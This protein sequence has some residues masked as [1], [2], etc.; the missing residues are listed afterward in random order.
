MMFSIFIF[1][2]FS[3]QFIFALDIEFGEYDEVANVEFIIAED[4]KKLKDGTFSIIEDG[5]GDKPKIKIITG[6]DE[7]ALATVNYKDVYNKMGWGHFHAH[8]KE[9]KEHTPSSQMYGAGVLEG[10]ITAHRI[11]EWKHNTDDMIKKMEPSYMG[12]RTNIEHMFTE[13]LNHIREKALMLKG[14]WKSDHSHIE[15]WWSQAR[16]MLMQAKGIQDGFNIQAKAKNVPLLTMV[17]LMMLSSDGETSELFKAYAQDEYLLRQEDSIADDATDDLL[18][19]NT[20]S[21]KKTDNLSLMQKLSHEE[22]LTAF[23]KHR[24]SHRNLQKER[25]RLHN[26]TDQDWNNI[27]RQTGRCSA[28]IKWTGDDLLTGHATWSDYA[29]MNRIFK[30]YDFPLP[31]TA[32]HKIS[33]SSYPGVAGST[34]DWYLMD[35]GLAVTETT[36]SMLS[37]E[38]YDHI[39]DSTVK[40]LIPDY[41]RIMA[42]NRLSKT[43]KDWVDMMIT[44]ATGTYSSQW[45]IIDYKLFKPNA[46]ALQPHTFWV[47]EQIPSMNHAQDMTDY[48]KKTSFW[49]SYNRA[50]YDETRKVMDVQFAET[51]KY[52]ALFGKATSPRANI[53]KAAQSTIKNVN[54]L[55]NLMRQNKWPLEIDGGPGNTADHAIAA[56]GD[57]TPYHS[58]FGAVDAKVTN[59]VLFKKLTSYAICGPMSNEKHQPFQWDQRPEYKFITHDGQPNIFNFQ[60]VAM[61]PSDI[62]LLDHGMQ[63]NDLGLLDHATTLSNTV[64]KNIQEHSQ[65]NVTDKTDSH[66]KEKTKEE[67]SQHDDTDKTD[68]HTVQE[69]NNLSNKVSQKEGTQKTVNSESVHSD[70]TIEKPL[71]LLESHDTISST[72]LKKRNNI[73]IQTK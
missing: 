13:Q 68:S 11:I 66:T 52:G 50:W 72:F 16:Y 20:T 58:P 30:F 2:L 73:I 47:L 45:M 43:G 69:K 60:W 62:T 19:N 33:F 54:D 17:D 23:R 22:K 70:T 34:D 39:N 49:A 25:E 63:S 65:D 15:K 67:L 27:V 46:K 59:H 5:K 32:A 28:F 71:T 3:P 51:G 44:S 18:N 31:D 37:D 7:H 24:A 61:T 1:S 64:K 14:D 53:F 29:E 40:N 38:Q 4:V 10:Y 12:A 41:M 8:F 48:L 42:A 35:N 9:S 36:I 26:L 56:R 6:T 55:Q 21:T 57:L